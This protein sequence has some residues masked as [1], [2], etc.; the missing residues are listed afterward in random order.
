MMEPISQESI[1]D[2]ALLREELVAYLDGELSVE[3]S[4]Q[5]E[6]RA[7]VEPGAHRMLTDFERTWHLLD[8]LES[9]PT[10]EDFTCTTLEMVALAAEDDVAKAKA[11]APRRRRRALVWT[12]A[13]LAGAAAL[14]FLLVWHVAPDPNAQLLQDLPLL[15]NYDQYREIGSFEFLRALCDEKLFAKETDRA[16]TNAGPGTEA[17]I[18]QRRRQVEAMNADQRKYLIHNE[19]VFSEL[20][21]EEKQHIRDLRDAI[22][23]DPDR[24]KLMVAMNR[25]CKWFGEQPQR[26]WIWDLQQKSAKDRVAEVKRQREKEK[27][28]GNLDA[29][30][31]KA[32]ARWMNSYVTEHEHEPRFVEAVLTG[33]LRG[34][35]GPASQRGAMLREGDA[36]TGK[37]AKLPAEEKHRV[38]SE[39][40]LRGWQLGNPLVHP[41]DA[42]LSSLRASL[43]T[44]IRERLEK[45]KPDE[46]TRIIAGWLGQTALLERDEGLADYFE[47]LSEEERDHLM[48]LP[49]DEIDRELGHL[50]MAHLMRTDQPHRGDWQRPGH[51][52]SG[53]AL[54]PPAVPAAWAHRRTANRSEVALRRQTRRFISSALLLSA[55]QVKPG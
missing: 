15:E 19:Q 21:P 26:W 27:T 51:P 5:V 12:V 47:T 30:N 43:S 34:G 6:E 24:D 52:R 39:M 13:G 10:S 4:R 2:D 49:G 45:K 42:E 44:D 35:R 3:Q 46:Q 17:T 37:F 22:E 54:R 25:Y 20:K 29:K 16:A 23:G 48:S 36:P 55:Q 8:E 7:R 38:L 28:G 18:D 9:P 40:V 50:Y 53:G 31:R 41:T 32:V 14:G 33:W 1:N 11:D